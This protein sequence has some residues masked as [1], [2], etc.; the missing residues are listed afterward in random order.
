MSIYAAYTWY[1]VGFLQR[2]LRFKSS[3]CFSACQRLP[4]RE[5]CAL[6]NWRPGRL[7]V[8]GPFS[9]ANAL[10]EIFKETLKPAMRGN[11]IECSR[12]HVSSTSQ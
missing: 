3:R 10:K 9:R 8:R 5:R 6:F 4:R 7:K 1:M 2:I 11:T 12:M